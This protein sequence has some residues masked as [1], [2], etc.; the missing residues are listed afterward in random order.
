MET[1][2][3]NYNPEEILA[4]AKKAAKQVADAL[5]QKKPSMEVSFNLSIS[6]FI[7]D[8]RNAFKFRFYS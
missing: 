3:D 4:K 2:S 1:V 5:M 8:K 6:C 7:F